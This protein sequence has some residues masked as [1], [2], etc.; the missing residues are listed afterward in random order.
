MRLMAGGAS[1]D[2]R[3]REGQGGAKGAT[4]DRCGAPKPPVAG[5]TETG[6]ARVPWRGVEDLPEETPMKL[7]FASLPAA[8]V[9]VLAGVASTRA[10]EIDVS[11]SVEAVTVYPDGA[12]VT[13]LIDIDLP[14]GDT[15][16]IAK[17][18]PPGLDPASLRVEGE[19]A[20]GV[21]IGAIDARPPRAERP[22]IAPEIEKR[23]ETLRD[24]RQV[25]DDR[26]AAETARK[27][28]AQRFATSVPLGVGEKGETRPLTE[29]RAAFGAVAEEI[30]AADSAMREARGKQRE[31]DRE[32]ARL[33]A[34]L[35]TNPS[36]KM[37]VRVDLAANGAGRSV[38]R[39]SYTV[40]GAR[41]SP[42]YDARLDSGARERK[43]ALELIRR[44]EIVQQTGEDWKDV[45]LSVSTVR[46]AKGGRA[47]ELSPLIVRFPQPLPP[48]RPM[49]G[50]RMEQQYAPA[51]A[52][53]PEPA[54]DSEVAKAQS[55]PAIER[56]AAVESSGYQVVYRVPGRISVVANEGAKSFRIASAR[57]APDLL[58]RATPALD[59][60]A[61]IEA[62]FRQD[63]EAPLLPGRIALYR[64]GIY[65]GRGQM[66]LT[67]KDE[68]VRLGFGADD[69][70]KVSRATLKQV[71]GSA[72]F[73][74]AA[75]TD[76]R[77]YKTTLRNHHEWPIKV[78]VEDQIPVSETE[79][80]KVEMLAVTP[81]PSERDA[82]ER[83]GVMVWNFDLAPGDSKEIKFGWRMRWPADKAIA[84]EPRRP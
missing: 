9:L 52:A 41:W 27:A 10:A 31:I 13:R 57:I 39:V 17:D 38:F 8:C 5:L 18:F 28:F 84:Y 26:I 14:A 81:P 74:S 30:A 12:T 67:P 63:D 37:E 73:V 77:E 54:Q 60:T 25:L 62:S 3:C 44:A 59:E 64:D 19:G 40:R 4:E 32:L 82:R 46:T 45:A 51:T 34:Q 76:R 43:P 48:P 70:V 29:W 72:G 50:G 42:L 24:E 20:A 6:I 47:P 35:K 80:I 75:K 21:T 58:A 65:V 2:M 83:R 71:E 56:E 66:A 68:T 33:D 22:V 11:S 61:F 79:D 7:L 23:I 53:A 55:A 16:L 69:K 15:T 1:N 78:V 49:L 36:R